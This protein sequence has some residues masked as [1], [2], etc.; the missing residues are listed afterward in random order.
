MEVGAWGGTSF[1]IG[2]ANPNT[3]FHRPLPAFG[4]FVRAN[5]SPRYVLKLSSTYGA[6]AGDTR[7]FSNKFPGDKQADFE[8]NFLDLGLNLEFNFVD[9]GLPSYSRD[10]RKFSP[11]I[12]IGAG[13][14]ASQD[15]FNNMNR[16]DFN[17]PFGVG[18]KY[19]FANRFNLGLEWSM[20]ILFVDDFDVMDEASKI[21]DNPYGHSGISSIKNKDKYSIAKIFISID[22]LKRT[23][24]K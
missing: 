9:Y 10:S 4:G 15:G 11:Y 17:F 1:Y 6:V 5:L 7:D 22:L 3:P 21:L 12:F 14:T 18:V 8:K 20:H 13:L 16:I 19:K 23:H 24:C 2:D